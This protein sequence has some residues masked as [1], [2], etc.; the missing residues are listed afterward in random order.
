M[1]RVKKYV[2]DFRHHPDAAAAAA[3]KER[4]CGV[5]YL[6]KRQKHVVY[7]LLL[8]LLRGRNVI[9]RTL[10]FASPDAYKNWFVGMMLLTASVVVVAVVVVQYRRYEQQKKI[11][12][13]RRNTSNLDISNPLVAM[14]Y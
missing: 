11:N 6:Y 3:V 5:C 2:G 9:T 7:L 14:T 8:L 13:A 4:V 12:P 1:P 10:K